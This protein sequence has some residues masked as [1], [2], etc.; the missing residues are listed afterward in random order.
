MSET[1]K[2]NKPENIEFETVSVPTEKLKSYTRPVLIGLAALILVIGGYLAY[3]NLYQEPQVQ[4]ASE[5]IFKAEQYFAEDSLQLALNG[6][7]KNAGF[8]KVI[9]N[10]GGTPSGNL[11]RLYAGECYLHLGDFNN[12]I[13][14]LK[15]FDAKGSKQV[16]ARVFG[17]LGDAYSELKKNDEAIDQYKKA[18]TVFEK[19][20]TTSS[21]YLFRAAN[22]Y[23]IS[24]KSKEAIELYK[25]ILAKYPRTEKGFQADKYLAR[26]GVTQ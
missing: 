24:G 12:A 19:D 10:Y 8:L 16:E 2:G 6:D 14:Y 26:L 13:K 3:K 25:T 20:A 23:E 4:K 17:M 15:E 11:A 21:E 1:K 5:A 18:G 9:K 7:G 22:L